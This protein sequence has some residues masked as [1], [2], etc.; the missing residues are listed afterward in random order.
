MGG[1]VEAVLERVRE[2]RARL[3]AAHE[4]DDAYE[5]A[6]AADELDDALRLARR[7]DIGTEDEGS[8]Q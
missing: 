7:Y 8:Q 5:V 1:F 3:E 2:A 6:L 4:A